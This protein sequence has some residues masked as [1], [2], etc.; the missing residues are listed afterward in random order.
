MDRKKKRLA[1]PY[2]EVMSKWESH[3]EAVIRE[4]LA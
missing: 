2:L 4:E 1:R 3:T